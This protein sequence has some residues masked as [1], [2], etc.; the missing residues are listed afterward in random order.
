MSNAE[1]ISRL[2]VSLPVVILAC[3]AGAAVLR[4]LRQPPVVGEIAVGILLGPSLLGR[5]WP[6]GR[7]YLFPQGVIDHIEVLGQLGLLAFM[8]FVGLELDLGRLRG[9]GRAAVVVSQCS[10]LV[11]LLLGSLLALAMYGSLAPHGVSKGAFVLFVAV[12]LSV[13]A[14]PVL[15]RILIDDGLY[16]TR[17]GSLA[18]TC[19]AANDVM[20]WC[21]LAIVVAVA[22][23]GT[24]LAFL[25]TLALLVGYFGVMLRVVRPA[26]ARASRLRRFTVGGDNHDG[27]VLVL[28][29]SGLC[30]SALA[31][32]AIGVH[33]IFGAFLFGL[34]VPRRTVAVE[35]AATRLRSVTEPLLLPL[36]FVTTG[37][38]T[39]IGLLA[40]DP[41]QWL[42]FS[43]VLFVAVVGKWGGGGGAARLSGMPWRESLVLGALLNCRGL[44][45]LIVLNVGLDLGVISESM[46]TMLVLVAMITTAVTS[47]AVRA[48]GT[49]ALTMA[50]HSVQKSE[51]VTARDVPER[52]QPG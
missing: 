41:Q 18:M 32:D 50:D 11:P 31:T 14:F 48:L 12:A 30:L 8:F 37:L 28:L 24:S 6:Q 47:P 3:R 4:R 33:A 10:I 51:R 29:F 9:N 7:E 17:L 43:A 36:F 39:D 40:S 13:T 52:S 1:Q 21:L 19:A 49:G 15:A 45:E 35:R 46:F 22:T 2:L 23:G 38:H 26:L 42:W 16:Y 27:L 25:T 5:L 34:V 44:T 20:A